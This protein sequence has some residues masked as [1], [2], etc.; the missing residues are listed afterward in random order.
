MCN[1]ENNLALVFVQYWCAF[2]CGFGYY[3]GLVKD[4]DK[5]K[6]SKKIMEWVS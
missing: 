1:Q 5:W 2:D 3:L 6:V 4:K